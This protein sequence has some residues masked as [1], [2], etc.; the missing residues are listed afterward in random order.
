MDTYPGTDFLV[1][2]CYGCQKRIANIEDGWADSDAGEVVCTEC[3][4][5]AKI[6]YPTSHFFPMKELMP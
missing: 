3:K 6:D 2:F 4:D 5:K 1:R